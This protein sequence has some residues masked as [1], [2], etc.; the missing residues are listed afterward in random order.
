MKITKTASGDTLKGT[1]VGEGT[2]SGG[3]PRSKDARLRTPGIQETAVPQPLRRDLRAF[4]TARPEGWNHQEW[5]DLLDGLRDHGYD[6]Q[7]ADE[8]GA[9]LERE[10]LGSLLEKVPGLG[11]KRVRAVA[12]KFG[13]LWRLRDA[14]ADE[15]SREANLPPAVADQIVA[16]VR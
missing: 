4:V 11:P 15:I 10:R 5:L 12:D 13:T 1:G 7:D 16:A 8:I 3:S 14:S 9:L 6:T 2:R